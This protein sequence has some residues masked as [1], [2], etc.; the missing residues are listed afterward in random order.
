MAHL[1]TIHPKPSPLPW[2]QWRTRLCPYVPAHRNPPAYTERHCAHT[3]RE[4]W[5]LIDPRVPYPIGRCDRLYGHR[6]TDTQLYRFGKYNAN[7]PSNEVPQWA[8]GVRWFYGG[9]D[10]AHDNFLDWETPWNA[11]LG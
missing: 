7:T 10:L 1:P 11:M 4:L 8:R 3:L 5:R 6:V 9:G 2:P